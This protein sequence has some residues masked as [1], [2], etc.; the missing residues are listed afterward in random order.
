MHIKIRHAGTRNERRSMRI[1]YNTRKQVRKPRKAKGSKTSFRGLRSILKEREEE[2]KRERK[3]RK[4]R[5]YQPTK[6]PQ[7]SSKNF[8]KSSKI[9]NF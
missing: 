6:S 5:R 2:E 9:I 3:E 4:E 8:R 1:T 7:N